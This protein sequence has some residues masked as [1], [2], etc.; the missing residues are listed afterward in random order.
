MASG[1]V[2]CNLTCGPEASH[3]LRSLSLHYPGSLIISVQP[4]MD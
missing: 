1:P 3:L 4:V 2:V